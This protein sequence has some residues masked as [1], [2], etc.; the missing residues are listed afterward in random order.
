MI[1]QRLSPLT[2]GTLVVFRVG[3][4]IRRFIPASAGNTLYQLTISRTRPVY[5]RWRGEHQQTRMGRAHIVGLSPLARGT[6]GKLL[7]DIDELRFI[8]AGA[9]NTWE[10]PRPVLRGAVYP[11][12]RGEHF[13][14]VG[15]VISQRV[16][17][18]LAR[19]THAVLQ[20]SL[21][22]MR[23]IPAGAGNT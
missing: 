12:W 20:Q 6:R 5:P 23:F 9:G 7:C 13:D 1:M 19:G 3:V 17:S 15:D 4:F 14:H 22:Q 16:L 10:K 18:P 8:P 21:L 2:R 11:R